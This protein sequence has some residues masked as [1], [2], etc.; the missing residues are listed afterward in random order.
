MIEGNPRYPQSGPTT[1][2]LLCFTVTM[3]GLTIIFNYQVGSRTVGRTNQY[4]NRVVACLASTT[5]TKRTPE[6]T[7]YC[8]DTVEKELNLSPERYGDG[9]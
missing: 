2:I 3:L 5:P 7:R 4:Y 8:Y 6:Y 9:K 1:L